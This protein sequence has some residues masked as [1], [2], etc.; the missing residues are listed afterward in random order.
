MKPPFTRCQN[1]TTVPLRDAL[2]RHFG[3]CHGVS[4]AERPK[5]TTGGGIFIALGAAVGVV[6]GRLFAQT[7]IGLVTG[8]AIGCA[9]AA[10]LWWREQR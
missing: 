9:L 2:A 3:T 1:G 7:S 4:M 8:F 6:V 5:N 10:L